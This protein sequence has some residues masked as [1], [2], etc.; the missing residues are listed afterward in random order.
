MCVVIAPA[1]QVALAAA[2]AIAQ[3][4]EQNRQANAQDKVNRAKSKFAQEQA[5]AAAKRQHA[6]LRRRQ[7]EKRTAAAAE[8]ESV[9]NQ[10]LKSAGL[11]RVSAA[12]SGAAGL[13]VAGVLADVARQES[14]LVRDV[15]R[16][17]EFEGLQFE[18]QG[19]GFQDQLRGRLFSSQFL[20]APRTNL[21]GAALN[22][23]AA[24]VSSVNQNTTIVDGKRQ[25]IG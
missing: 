21:L 15:E 25:F 9:T 2:T 1:V 11:A 24:T 3:Q 14:R 12:S 7:D 20:P 5:N 22:V 4:V 13:A 17:Q 19:Q 23:G 6:A 18:T 16:R 10:A 8:I